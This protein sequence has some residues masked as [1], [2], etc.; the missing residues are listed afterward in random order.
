MHGLQEQLATSQHRDVELRSAAYR[1]EVE[2]A[3]RKYRYRRRAIAW[4]RLSRSGDW[5][6]RWAADRAEHARR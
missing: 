1:P 4:E 2:A 5:L 3:R 6:S